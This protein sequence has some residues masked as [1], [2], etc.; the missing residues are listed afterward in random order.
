MILSDAL[1]SSN[2]WHLIW[3]RSRDTKIATQSRFTANPGATTEFSPATAKTL[4]VSVTRNTPAWSSCANGWPGRFVGSPP[5][6][7]T[8][9]HVVT[10][11]EP[12]E[13]IDEF[14]E[15]FERVSRSI[16]VDHR[17]SSQFPVLSSAQC[18]NWRITGFTSSTFAGPQATTADSSVNPGGRF[19]L[20]EF[21]PSTARCRL[22][23]RPRGIAPSGTDIE[24]PT[25]GTTRR[26][27]C[28]SIMALT[29]KPLPSSVA[30]RSFSSGLSSSSCSSSSSF[31]LSG[32]AWYVDPENVY[33]KLAIDEE[34]SSVRGK[35]LFKFIKYFHDV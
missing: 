15:L 20:K 9:R 34:L 19:G 28:S 29:M 6:I 22:C 8:L 26:A 5:S 33:I 13:L 2:M 11:G 23:R 7:S 21:S 12:L 1:V 31:V 17:L 18:S 32:L 3:S 10:D 30:D 27:P 4:G 25:S 24:T 16:S 35:S 14:V